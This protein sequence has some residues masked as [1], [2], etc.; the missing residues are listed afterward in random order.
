MEYTTTIIIAIQQAYG[1]AFEERTR[2][3]VVMCAQEIADMLKDGDPSFDDQD[4]LNR[5]LKDLAHS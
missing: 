1:K 2:S 3:G 5:S 4:F